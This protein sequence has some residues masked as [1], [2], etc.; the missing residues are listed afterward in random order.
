[1]GCGGSTSKVSDDLAGVLPTD[2]PGSALASRRGE[3]ALLLGVAPLPVEYDPLVDAFSSGSATAV[4]RP[5][6]GRPT[7][8]ALEFE[9]EWSSIGP[10]LAAMRRATEAKLAGATESPPPPPPPQTTQTEQQAQEVKEDEEAKE[11]GLAEQQ[12]ADADGDAAV[13]NDDSIEPPSDPSLFTPL[14]SAFRH[15][16]NVVA[17][18]FSAPHIVA[19]LA[20]LASH[21]N[22]LLRIFPDLDDEDNSIAGAGTDADAIAKKNAHLGGVSIGARSKSHSVARVALAESGPRFSESLATGRLTVRLFYAGIWRE[23]EIDDAVPVGPLR[24]DSGG[25]SGSSSVSQPLFTRSRDCGESW[26]CVVEKALAR[27]RGSFEDLAFTSPL[28]LARLLTGGSAEVVVLPREC[29]RE[30]AETLWT[31]LRTAHERE[32]LLCAT[33]RQTVPTPAANHQH[34]AP[35][36]NH[37]NA[38]GGLAS[39]R[40]TNSHRD[41]AASRRGSLLESQR[42]ALVSQHGVMALSSVPNDLLT[43][44]EDLMA[45][46]AELG[47]EAYYSVLEVVELPSSLDSTRLILLRS[48]L[49]TQKW[50]GRW[51]D[52]S[53]EWTT[54][55]KREG[56]REQVERLRQARNKHSGV[57]AASSASS[58]SSSSTSG[59]FWLAWED[60]LAHFACL[61]ACSVLADR[62]DV[63]QT[64]SGEW[65]G[66]SAAGRPSD[67]VTAAPSVSADSSSSADDAYN[68]WL[69]NPQFRVRNT[70]NKKTGPVVITLSR[71]PRLC[72]RAN[73][74][75]PERLDG[76]APY[77]APPPVHIGFRVVASQLNHVVNC[78]PSVASPLFGQLQASP[79]HDLVATTSFSLDETISLTLP[80]LTSYT[81]YYI[82]PYTLHA[83]VEGDFVVSVWSNSPAVLFDP[84]PTREQDPLE[85]AVS[86]RR[87][88]R[89]A[90]GNLW[91]ETFF[92]NPMWRVRNTSEE[93]VV[94]LL[95]HLVKTRS[96]ERDLQLNLRVLANSSPNPLFATAVG[97][98]SAPPRPIAGATRRATAERMALE[99]AAAA[100]EEKKRARSGPPLAPV[101][102]TLSPFNEALPGASSRWGEHVFYAAQHAY[103]VVVSGLA[104][105]AEAFIVASTFTSGSEG[106]ALLQVYASALEHLQ[107]EPVSRDHLR[108]ISGRWIG[109]SAAGPARRKKT[110]LNN[111]MFCVRHQGA[112][113]ISIVV[114]L[115]LP[116]TAP[117]ELAINITVATTAPGAEEPNPF[118]AQE[119]DAEKRKRKDAQR[120]KEREAEA[121]KKKDAAEKARAQAALLGSGKGAAASSSA[122]MGVASLRL[123]PRAGE[124]LAPLAVSPSGA[125]PLGGGHRPRKSSVFQSMDATA[126][127]KTRLMS[128]TPLLASVDESAPRLNPLTGEYHLVANT[129]FNG[130]LYKS[131]RLVHL[132]VPNIEPGKSYFIIPS[133][134]VPGQ[135]AD[136]QLQVYGAS[137]ALDLKLEPCELNEPTAE[138]AAGQKRET[139]SS[140]ECD[141]KRGDVLAWCDSALAHSLHTWP[142]PP[143][144]LLRP[145]LRYVRPRLSS[146]VLRRRCRTGRHQSPRH[147]AKGRGTTRAAKGGRR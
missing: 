132:F 12:P 19:A 59:L 125:S 39:R 108:M 91:S 127:F 87:E 6:V 128:S 16:D 43:P 101:L 21:P 56:G 85:L 30:H 55:E 119:R 130:D 22:R 79:L 49:G 129:S 36:A 136:F 18:P 97:C 38:N 96:Q 72:A 84:C 53:E 2:G 28:S 92:D 1:M 146:H 116:P 76:A 46:H 123:K 69:R 41:A 106:E 141:V 63:C 137:A 142:L 66:R 102:G 126:S 145:V 78:N 120:R 140:V 90:G 57:A 3:L 139:G 118:S 54:L 8:L 68:L 109:A 122:S 107:V 31:Q 104:P 138:A 131:A 80:S 111:P 47:A 143:P 100:A 135:E 99:A 15:E 33:T 51:S 94:K 89:T 83:G 14:F 61:F 71:G 103:P 44:A 98:A 112:A 24:R 62:F 9:P 67:L 114:S 13:A 26:M 65:Q 7:V 95:L 50:Q 74:A 115:A 93:E 42:G 113:P 75:P 27:V 20:S 17:G 58:S 77:V 117:V 70:S 110:F 32:D 40:G 34:A 10:T 81:D 73:A 5:F 4:R 88:D 29:S 45:S 11:D 124:K 133:T 134:S 37:Q 35:H 64:L 121:K 144:H 25:S 105:G 48:P 82:I 86:W 60:L 147:R 23:F 52:E